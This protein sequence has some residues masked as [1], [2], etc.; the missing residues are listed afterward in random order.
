MIWRLG[1]ILAVGFTLSAGA[2]ASPAPSLVLNPTTGPPNS[3]VTFA[4]SGFCGTC[5]AVTL[6][7]N[8]F[9]VAS[10]VAV[11]SDGKF[12]GTFEV[13]ATPAG[14]QRVVASQPGSGNTATAL[15]FVGPSLPGPTGPHPTVSFTPP[16][17][18]TPLVTTVPVSPTTS[19]GSPPTTTPAP[20]TL[21]VTSSASS[22]ASAAGGGLGWLV[23]LMLAVAVAAVVAGAV[24]LLRRR[25]RPPA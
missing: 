13:P 19:P 11:G 15:Y 9:P 1:I 7:F 18:P 16:P 3:V 4:G 6:T 22:A 20:G 21:P 10:G 5:G 17:G 23:W 24:L 12:H 8:N 2:A 14:Q 25:A